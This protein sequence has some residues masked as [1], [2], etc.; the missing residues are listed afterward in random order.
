[1][2]FH[3]VCDRRHREEELSLRRIG[4]GPDKCFV[5]DEIGRLL[6][7]GSMNFRN[8]AIMNFE[9]EHLALNLFSE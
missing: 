6:N 5:R 4:L 8:G 7:L 9:K 3:S 1:M 2:C